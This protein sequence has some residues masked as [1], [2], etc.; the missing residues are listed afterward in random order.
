[1]AMGKMIVGVIAGLLLIGVGLW[2][3]GI[4]PKIV[5]AWFDQFGCVADDCV[6]LQYNGPVSGDNP[7]PDDDLWMN[8][9]KK[10]IV[11]KP[12]NYFFRYKVENL[13]KTDSCSLWV[14]DTCDQIL[15]PR[16][17]KCYVYS[18]PQKRD[19]TDV[20]RIQVLLFDEDGKQFKASKIRINM[21][22]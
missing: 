2:W 15:C 4:I 13:K 10:T 5:P 1:M 3:L 18:T 6:R 14:Y 21:P 19:I 11:L 8:V 12:G 17:N 16:E 22:S 7:V 20:A 9:S